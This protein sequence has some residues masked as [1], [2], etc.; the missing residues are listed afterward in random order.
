MYMKSRLKIL[1]GAVNVLK[2]QAH[3][4]IEVMAVHTRVW[5][6]ISPPWENVVAFLLHTVQKKKKMVKVL[7][8]GFGIA[9]IKPLIQHP[10]K[11]QNQLDIFETRKS[12]VLL[13][14]VLL[15]IG[16]MSLIH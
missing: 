6:Y 7:P 2:K 14:P 9:F 10:L 8:P 3:L 4:T 5:E 15:S 13:L 12:M 1:L 16:S 11:T